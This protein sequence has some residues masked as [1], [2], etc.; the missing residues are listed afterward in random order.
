M[1]NTE[2]EKIGIIRDKSEFGNTML[3][4]KKLVKK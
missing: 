1:K 2:A 4:P 3:S